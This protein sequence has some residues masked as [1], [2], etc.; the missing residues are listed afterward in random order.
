MDRRASWRRD[1]KKLDRQ[2]THAWLAFAS[3][4]VSYQ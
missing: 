1:S 4:N 3:A 2:G